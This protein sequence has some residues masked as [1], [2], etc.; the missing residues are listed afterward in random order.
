MKV[1]VNSTPIIAL[2]FVSKLWILNKLFKEVIIP[3]S[4]FEELTIAGKGK[5]GSK[6]VNETIWLNQKQMGILFDKSPKTISEHI[7]NIFK[8]WSCLKNS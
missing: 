3:Q 5:V 2:S 7:N 1:V 8:F 4:V 6:E